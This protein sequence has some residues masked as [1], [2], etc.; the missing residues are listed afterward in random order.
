[1][2]LNEE[3]N[4]VQ[5]WKLPLK[6]KD[7]GRFII[8]CFI[9][10]KFSCKALYELG[11][12]INLMS[13]SIYRKLGLGEVKITTLK[14]QLAN[15]SYIFPREKIENILVKVD[16]FIFPVNFVL[17]DMEE[18]KDVPLVMGRP[19]LATGRTLIDV[20]TRKLIMRVKINKW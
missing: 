12:S 11:A 16:K 3:C 19:F 14:L 18:D 7:L 2:A 1:M 8:P 9:G 13:L 17:L 10:S 4:A 5:Q 15:K 20:A 6:L